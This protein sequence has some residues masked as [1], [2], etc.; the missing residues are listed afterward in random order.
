MSFV[1]LLKYPVITSL[2]G[3]KRSVLNDELFS[4]KII[5]EYLN[6]IYM[7]KLKTVE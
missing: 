1:Q 6:I 2:H 3:T 5:T 4:V 7:N